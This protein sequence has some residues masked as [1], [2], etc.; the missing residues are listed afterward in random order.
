MR[1]RGHGG[2]CAAVAVVLAA[3]LSAC[4]S[5]TG[6]GGDAPREATP[7]EEFAPGRS[8][9]VRDLEVAGD[10]IEVEVID[11]LAIYQGDIVLGEF[12]GLQERLDAAQL[13]PQ[14]A[15]CAFDFGFGC[16]IWEGGVVGYWIEGDWGPDQKMM[17]DR[18]EDAM[19]HWAQ[20]TSI[21]FQKRAAGTR[22]VIRDGDGCSSAIGRTEITGF[23]NQSITLSTDCGFGTVVH[24]LGHAIGFWH[25]HSRSDRNSHVAVDFGAVED[26][27]LHNFFTHAGLGSDVGPYDHGSIMHYPC[28]GFAKDG[29]QTIIPF[30]PGIGCREDDPRPAR[31]IGQRDALSDGDILGAYWLYPPEFEIAGATPGAS[32]S[33]FALRTQFSTEPVASRFIV[34]ESDRLPEPLGDGYQ[35]DLLSA[36]LPEG[37][38][39]ITATI[40]INETPLVSDTIDL[41]LTRSAPVVDLGPDLEAERNKA[42]FLTATVSDADDGTCPIAECGYVWDPEP[43]EN[44]GG[45]TAGYRFT[46][47]GE[48]TIEL[49]VTD[50]GGLTGSDAV[51]VTVVD[52]PP[53]PS[54]DSP[55][56]GA[57]F[58][59]GGG[60][61]EVPLQG[62]ATDANEGEGDGPGSLPCSALSWSV[63]GAGASI[64][65]DDGCTATLVATQPGTVTVSL[66]A[67][68]VLGQETTVE[69]DVT[70]TAC[71]GN[72]TPNVSF[73]IT[74]SADYT[75][76]GEPGYY[77]G[78]NIEATGSIDDA[79][80]PPDNPIA[81]TWTL[82]RPFPDN[83][84]VIDNGTVNDPGAGPASLPVDF[85]PSA[86]LGITGWSNCS[87]VP[88]LHTLILEVEDDAGNPATY[89]ESFYLRCILF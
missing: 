75:Y 78:T 43:T 68:D 26:G 61:V 6:G 34:W 5:G 82:L 79:D 60:S 58:V 29:R 9:E 81:Y 42:V 10:S 45:G 16:G 11:G 12:E 35:V 52:S 54:I 53:E 44:S 37:D 72:C 77:L 19:E 15:V 22:V 36:D 51:V 55:G 40:V 25:E 67:E 38:H 69:R 17:E 86:D 47:T 88:L 14:A 18:I 41:T 89:Q 76:E 7:V 57:S 63:S 80:A 66:T 62:S 48:R 8:G 46:T 3:A 2:F 30:I 32:G 84:P 85:T 27:K 50:P 71:E 28:F 20:R 31:H 23:D 49:T 24:E 33:A 56:P 64:Q 4:G 13:S 70:F 21:R 87:T 74:T 65:D 39:T 83:D 59:V 1:N 73:L